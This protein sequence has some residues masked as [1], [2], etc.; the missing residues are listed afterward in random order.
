M[1][2]RNRSSFQIK[3]LLFPEQ[4]THISK[5]F[6][7]NSNKELEAKQFQS[8]EVLF[9]S[10]NMCGNAHIS[11]KEIRNKVHIQVQSF[12][13]HPLK[14]KK[15]RGSSP[16]RRVPLQSETKPSLYCWRSWN[17]R[18]LE[19]H[20]TSGVSFL[21]DGE[22]RNSGDRPQTSRLWETEPS[23]SL[24][25]KGQRIFNILKPKSRVDLSPSQRKL[26]ANPILHPLLSS[27]LNPP[28]CPTEGSPHTLHIPGDHAKWR[29]PP[30]FHHP[31]PAAFFSL[32]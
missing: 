6:W 23:E 13:L 29:T 14:R 3:L 21:A 20:W 19:L 9:A 1:W 25:H 4:S 15:K 28:T 22:S 24:G 16:S 17:H 8:P 2:T 26:E 7:P 11:L 18:I 12:E 5:A 10:A 32:G 27:V 30:Q 31:P